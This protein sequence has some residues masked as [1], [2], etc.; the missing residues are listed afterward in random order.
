[1]VHRGEIVEQAVRQSGMAITEVA[2]R[3]GK[4]RRH[5]YN[6]FEEPNISLD[7]VLQIGEIIHHDFTKELPEL[8]NKIKSQAL[9]ELDAVYDKS[10]S[11]YW[12]DKYLSLLEKYNLLLEEVNKQWDFYFNLYLWFM[13]SHDLF[14]NQVGD[15]Q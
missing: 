6:L 5:I 14:L 13:A 4:S 1:M 10:D 12:K 11:D 8:S 3:L 2:R 7:V 9:N 15:F